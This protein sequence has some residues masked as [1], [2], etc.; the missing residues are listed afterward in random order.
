MHWIN[1]KRKPFYSEKH[2]Y[3]FYDYS[4]NI[5]QFADWMRSQDSKYNLRYQI[6]GHKIGDPK[7]KDKFVSIRFAKSDLENWT[8]ALKYMVIDL[9]YLLAWVARY[10]P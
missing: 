8:Q 1:S 3:S 4:T 10:A 5:K 9:K 7:K 2:S 6:N